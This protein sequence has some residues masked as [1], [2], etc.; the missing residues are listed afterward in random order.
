MLDQTKIETRK[1]ELEKKFN[2]LKAT[3]LQLIAQIQTATKAVQSIVAEMSELGGA[4]KEVCSV[5]G[6]D[7]DVE[8]NKN[9]EKFKAEQ[10]KK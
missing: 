6:L 9:E 2:E 1:A 3:R 4:Y 8:A 10:V 7:A 5:L